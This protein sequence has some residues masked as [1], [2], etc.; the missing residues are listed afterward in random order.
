[1]NIEI[2]SIFWKFFFCKKQQTSFEAFSDIK[3]IFSRVEPQNESTFPFQYDIIFDI[4]LWS[5][6]LPGEIKHAR[7]LTFLYRI[8]CSTTFISSVFSYNSYFW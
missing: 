5:P 2:I 1:M 3:S 7:P 6:P 4:N 8:Q